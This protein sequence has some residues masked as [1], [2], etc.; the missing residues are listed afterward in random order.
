[1][2]LRG[3]SCGSCSWLVGYRTTWCALVARWRVWPLMALLGWRHCQAE[4][5]HFFDGEPY[6]WV[7]PWWLSRRVERFIVYNTP[8]YP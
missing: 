7:R 6:R 1:M 3:V 5:A 4:R 8:E 2:T